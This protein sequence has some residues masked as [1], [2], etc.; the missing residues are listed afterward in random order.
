MIRESPNKKWLR[1]IGAFCGWEFAEN[2]QLRHEQYMSLPLGIFT[3]IYE[4]IDQERLDASRVL[5]RESIEDAHGLLVLAQ[6]K[7]GYGTYEGSGIPHVF[8]QERVVQSELASAHT[9]DIDPKNYGAPRPFAET[10]APQ[11]A[12][13]KQEQAVEKPFA[14]PASRQDARPTAR[15]ARRGVWHRG[16]P[17]PSAPVPAGWK[18]GKLG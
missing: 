9:I 10:I 14:R 16:N 7:A 4:Q 8:D 17:V 2:K 3:Q 12:K 15:H 5:P 18:P 11:L 1:E 13:A 6:V